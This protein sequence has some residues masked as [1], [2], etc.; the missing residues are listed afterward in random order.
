MATL[1][2]AREQENG[3]DADRLLPLVAGLREVL[4]WV[5]QWHRIFDRGSASLTG[6]YG[7]FYA[8]KRATIGEC[9]LATW[10]LESR[11]WLDATLE[12]RPRPVKVVPAGWF[13]ADQTSRT[14]A[15]SPLTAFYSCRS[16]T[17]RCKKTSQPLSGGSKISLLVLSRRSRAYGIV[18]VRS[19]IPPYT[20]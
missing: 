16:R 2:V 4:P 12:E 13:S 8:V 1:F 3:W 6:T 11:D 20:I 10:M 19:S 18:G 5:R 14:M 9:E 17:A 7:R 15:R